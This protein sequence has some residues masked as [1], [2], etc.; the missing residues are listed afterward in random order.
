MTAA[1]LAICDLVHCGWAS[2]ERAQSGLA[3]AK[4]DKPTTVSRPRPFSP[5]L[6]FHSTAGALSR[7]RV[8][9]NCQQTTCFLTCAVER[10]CFSAGAKPARQLA[11]QPVAIGA[12][13]ASVSFVKGNR[14]GIGRRGA[15]LKVCTDVV[16]VAQRWL[17]GCASRERPQTVPGFP[18][19][20]PGAGPGRRNCN[21]V[22]DAGVSFPQ[23]GLPG[24]QE[25]VVRR[26]WECQESRVRVQSSPL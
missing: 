17:A 25:A 15:G 6:P 8:A 19:A 7:C 11:L 3:F 5:R 13:R 1:Y 4:T 26:R 18:W 20:R 21:Q 2:R 14:A 23:S 24:E 12:V 9:R 16:G 10:R 22:S